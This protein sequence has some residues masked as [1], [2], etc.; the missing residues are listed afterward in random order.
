MR[1][2]VFLIL[3]LAGTVIIEYLCARGIMNAPLL[4]LIPFIAAWAGFDMFRNAVKKPEKSDVDKKT[5]G[6]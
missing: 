3:G 5:G 1:G 2:L 6:A 4:A